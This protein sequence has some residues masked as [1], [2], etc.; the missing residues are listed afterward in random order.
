M[1]G[2]G[3]ADDPFSILLH[4]FTIGPEHVRASIRKTHV[5]VDGAAKEHHRRISFRRSR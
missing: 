2:Q 5:V 4:D 3:F 1:W